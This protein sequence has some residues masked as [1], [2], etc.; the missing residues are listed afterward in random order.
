MFISNISNLSRVFLFPVC[1][2]KLEAWTGPRQAWSANSQRQRFVRELKYAW[3]RRSRRWGVKYK[4][5]CGGYTTLGY[6]YGV[7]WFY[8]FFLRLDAAT[9]TVTPSSRLKLKD[10]Y[11]I[12]IEL[13]ENT[14]K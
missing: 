3:D 6:R 1:L 9:D 2:A 11:G 7:L 8:V 14:E 13:E 12:F 10:G 5:G 4:F